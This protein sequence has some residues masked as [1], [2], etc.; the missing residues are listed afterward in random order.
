MV[1]E[2]AGQGKVLALAAGRVVRASVPAGAV[3]MAGDVVVVVASNDPVVRI[4]VPEREARDLKQGDAVR[5]VGEGGVADGRPIT[6]RIREIYPEIRN[7][8]VTADLE[9]K[10]IDLGIRRPTRARVGGHGRT[11]R[12][13][14]CRRISSPRDLASTM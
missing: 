7:G 3:V 2:Q 11:A 4:E 6:A 10:G 14:S 1:S 8:R 12:R 5:L 13:S 9:A